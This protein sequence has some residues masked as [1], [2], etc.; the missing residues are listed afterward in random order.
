M[1]PAAAALAP[2]QGIAGGKRLIGIDPRRLQ[3]GRHLGQMRLDHLE[4]ADRPAEL[5]AGRGIVQGQVQ[6][7]LCRPQIGRAEEGALDVEA[8]HDDADALVLGPQQVRRGHPHTLE[9]QLARGA[10]APAHLGERLGD[11]ET[12]RPRLDHEGRDALGAEVRRGLGIGQHQI[13]HRP[14]RDEHLAAGQ[15]VIPAIPHRPQGHRPQR[16]GA[17]AGLGQAQ[18][19]DLPPGDQVGDEACDLLG[20]AV[21]ED[22]VEAQVLVRAPDE[23]G[24]GV[25]IAEGLADQP[26]R[27][28]IHPRP[29]QIRRRGQ[30]AIAVRTQ[31]GDQ[32]GGKPILVIHPGEQRVQLGLGIAEG[33]VIKAALV[34]GQVEL[35]RLIPRAMARPARWPAER[36]GGQ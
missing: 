27:D 21:P 23:G 10:A 7:A 22:V 9:D 13:R 28:Q 2:A 36:P 19:A 16:V 6:T 20:R 30:P 1:Y 32:I 18:R 34:V 12:G 3:C 29:A 15:H 17:R 11:R 26:G 25:P 5:L 35:H 24:V 4:A 14:V 8:R 33:G 31:P